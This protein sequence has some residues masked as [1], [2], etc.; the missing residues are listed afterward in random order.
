[1]IAFAVLLL[2]AALGA[3]LARATR[4]PSAPIFILSGGFLSAV[5]NFQGHLTE[6]KEVVRDA[7][8][9]GVIFLVFAAGLRLNPRVLGE[10]WLP[11]LKVATAQFFVLGALGGLLAY[12]L[13]FDL[14]TSGY[15]AV[16]LAASSTLVGY[17]LLSSRQQL[18]EP[19]GRLTVGVLLVQDL[20]VIVLLAIV[21]H[22]TESPGSIVSAVL[23]MG[24]LIGSAAAF[25]QTLGKHLVTRW[26][27]SEEVRLM[28]VLAVLFLFVGIADFLELPLIAG[29]FLGGL[30]LSAFPTDS[31]VKGQLSSMEDFFSAAFFT[32]LG[33]TLPHISWS[34]APHA[35]VFVVL[36][37]VVTPI[38][39]T[40]VGE[41]S[42]YTTRASLESGLMLS[43][44]SEFSLVATFIGVNS[45]HIEQHVFG[46]VALITVLTMLTTPVLSTDIMTWRLLH[47]HPNFERKGKNLD[48]QDHIVLIGA[49]RTGYQLLQDLLAEG[50]RVAVIDTDP[51]RVAQLEAEDTPAVRGDGADP[52]ALAKVAADR[53]LAVLSTLP[54]VRENERLLKAVNG[55]LVIARVDDP[56]QFSRIESLGGVPVSYIDP[57]KCQLLEWLGE[58]EAGYQEIP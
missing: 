5:A 4:L 15:L 38:V 44:T 2:G 22:L 39:V 53:A 3:G 56:S 36:I 13:G 33:A 35:L 32:S 7:L 12:V 47:F 16:A 6:E 54:R 10:K 40:V 24:L 8:I 52:Q 1:M 25:N 9:L 51:G 11:V 28:A 42:G 55:P 14:V 49:G 21:P 34:I 29:A 48:L 43:Q 31:L 23:K 57:A 37:I 26:A 58:L 27:Q 17:G 50:Y 30:A 18:F 19:F 41:F 46:L 20:L 45:G